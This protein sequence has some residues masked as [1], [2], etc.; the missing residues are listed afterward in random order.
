MAWSFGDG[1]D[2]YATTADMASGY[3]TSAGSMSGT[4]FVAGR[5]AGSQALQFAASGNFLQKTGGANDAVHHIICAFRQTVAISGTTIGTYF[6]LVDGAANQCSVVFRSDGAILLVGGAANSGTTLATYTGA[7]PVINTWY[8]FEIEVFIS[9]TAGY[10]NVRKNGNT[11]NDFAS[12]T[13][14]NTRVGTSN[15]YANG[16]TFGMNI[17]VNAQQIDDLLWRSDASSVSFAGDLRC[18]TRMPASDAAVQFSRTPATLP[19]VLAAG[20]ASSQAITAGTARYTPFTAAYD[21]TIGS[22]TVGFVSG[23]TGNLKCSIFASFGAVP[24]T[25]LG[26]ANVLTNP[27]TGVNTLTFATPVAVVKG[28]S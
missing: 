8:A 1:F 21:G 4:S 23:Y 5:F 15:A 17:V 26:S 7:F 20:A 19:Q 2:C 14:L 25:V 11:S 13:N 27:A 12:A 6:T 3:W 16:L 24:T 22:L 18:F 9:A 28:T 10:M